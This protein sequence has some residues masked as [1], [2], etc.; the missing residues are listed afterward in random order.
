[1]SQRE[2]LS[3]EGALFLKLPADWQ[4]EQDSEDGHYLFYAPHLAG[5][6]LVSETTRVA[7]PGRGGADVGALADELGEHFRG[8]ATRLDLNGIPAVRS[9]RLVEDGGRRQRIRQW[10]A[11]DGHTIVYVTHEV[12][13][14]VGEREDG[15]VDTLL[16]SMELRNVPHPII[17]NLLQRV[18]ARGTRWEWRQS[19]PLVIRSLQSG[20]E[21]NA[22]SLVRAIDV[23]PTRWNRALDDLVRKI[24][25][26]DAF[27]GGAPTW[28]EVGDSLLPLIRGATLRE[29]EAPLDGAALLRREW[30]PGL[31][32]YYAVDVPGAFRFVSRE[33]AARWGVDAAAVEARATKNLAVRVRQ[34]RLHF[35][36]AEP[37]D[38]LVLEDGEGLAASRLLVE[39]FRLALAEKLGPVYVVALPSAGVLI[40]FPEGFDSW[41]D[42]LGED[43]WEAYLSEP[44]PITRDLY[45]V[46]PGGITKVPDA[47]RV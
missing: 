13:A 11:S 15:E 9:D 20:Q 30:G 4:W 21:L 37:H 43:V 14:D 24:A 8:G 44:V 46:G 32:V 1:M 29:A 18:N 5:T 12:A 10:V 39:R 26:L 38:L 19:E 6:L 7:T 25:N 40:A 35:M 22:E 41:L 28:S 23:Q 16:Q 45:R 34:E 17:A 2:F 47:E 3:P 31:W 33:H 36:P 42:V 27:T